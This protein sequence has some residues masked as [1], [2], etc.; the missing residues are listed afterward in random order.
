MA[1][2]V[3]EAMPE[4]ILSTLE[5]CGAFVVSI[6]GSGVDLMAQGATREQALERI[7]MQASA[8]Y[9]FAKR[10]SEDV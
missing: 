10:E 8:E 7:A 6:T 3:T 5:E 2:E 4:L 9:L 1:S